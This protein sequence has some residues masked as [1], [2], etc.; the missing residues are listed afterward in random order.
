E[1]GFVPDL[2]A[3][4]D[5]VLDRTTIVYLCSPTNPQGGVMS[6]AQIKAA[7]QLARKHE[8]LLVMD[9]CYCDIWRGTPPPGALE[10]AAALHREEGGPKKDPLRNLV[11]LN[12]LSKR[13][14]AAGLRAGFLVGDADVMA[15]YLKVISNTG[16]LVPTPLLHAAADLYDDDDHVAAIRAHY[17]HSFAFATQHLGTPPPDGGFF[18]WLPVAD[19]RRFVKRLMAEKAVRV[20]PGSFMAEASDGINPGAGYVR[21]AL[22]HDHAQ[23]EESLARVAVVYDGERRGAA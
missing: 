4:P 21:M 5:D 13:S 16:S 14:S 22:V 6:L 10:A 7:I 17:D 2:G 20:M 18:L 3:Q 15:L 9:E 19:D 8:F 11:V 1:D 12:S 23:T